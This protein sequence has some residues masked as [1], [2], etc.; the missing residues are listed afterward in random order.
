ML[1]KRKSIYVYA[2]L[3]IFIGSS[4]HANNPEALEISAQDLLNIP[5][6][7]YILYDV[8]GNVSDAYTPILFEETK[9]KRKLNAKKWNKK[10][11]RNTKG[12][13]KNKRKKKRSNKK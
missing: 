2:T 5:T 12:S 7:N 6:N 13:K 3:A 9:Q 11:K 4:V 1:I 8:N 10:N